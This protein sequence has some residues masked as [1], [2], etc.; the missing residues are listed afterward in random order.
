MVLPTYALQRGEERP[1]TDQSAACAWRKFARVGHAVYLQSFLA[2][3]A[4][5]AREDLDVRGRYVVS[6]A[7]GVNVE[8]R[9]GGKLVAWAGKW[10][11]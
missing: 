11:C 10:T 1:A 2:W 7:A 3:P 9:G 6:T 8:R 5:Q 4:S